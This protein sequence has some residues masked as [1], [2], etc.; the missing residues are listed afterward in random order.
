MKVIVALA[1]VVLFAHA[2]VAFTEP[3]HVDAHSMLNHQLPPPPRHHQP[4]PHSLISVESHLHNDAALQA[5][6]A[7]AVSDDAI[8]AA[9]VEDTVT[10]AGALSAEEKALVE[11]SSQRMEHV[12]GTDIPVD[13]P[14]PIEFMAAPTTDADKMRGDGAR[15]PW[16]EKLQNA[17]NTVAS[18]ATFRIDQIKR[19]SKW[20]RKATAL[21]NELSLKKNKVSNHVAHLTHEIK[22]LLHKKKQIQNKQLQNKLVARLKKTHTNLKRI[23]SQNHNIRKNEAKMLQQKE[24]LAN[25]LEGI[26]RS[27]ALLKGHKRQR[28][29]PE[30]GAARKRL[31]ELAKFDPDLS[32]EKEDMEVHAITFPDQVLAEVDAT[33][34]L[35]AEEAADSELEADLE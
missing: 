27:L 24:A 11:Q 3:S 13:K 32:N 31:E 30:K 23:R 1:M 8:L 9:N 19:Q 35:E 20:S 6:E 16:P 28:M 17:L 22:D 10:P 33:E 18:A 2:C 25:S 5:E 7:L 14:V 21:V 15:Y 34:D 26:K 4:Q 29:F 12:Q